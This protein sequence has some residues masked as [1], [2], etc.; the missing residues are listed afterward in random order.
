MAPS[1]SNP[2]D[3]GAASQEQAVA[4]VLQAMRRA[5]PEWAPELQPCGEGLGSQVWRAE[6]PAWGPVAIRVPRQRIVSNANEQ[7][8]ESRALL[9]QERRLS[10]YLAPFGLPVP[11]VFHLHDRDP[12]PYF[13]VTAYVDND[14]TPADPVAVGRLLAR[15][16]AV[17]A[18]PDWTPVAQVGETLARTLATR[19][20][21][22]SR[23]IELLTGESLTGESLT[24][25]ALDVP[26]PEELE[27]LLLRTTGARSLLHLD[28]REPNILT[29]R[30]AIAGL[31]DWDNCLIGDPALEIAR[32]SESGLW[33][34]SM[35]SG[36]G[37]PDP[38]AAIPEP[39][40]LLYRLYTATMLALVFLSEAPDPARATPAVERVRHLWAQYRRHAS[41]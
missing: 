2:T 32:V 26:G 37:A 24:G 10:A 39:V 35:A 40:A 31:I 7:G 41:Q 5:L 18:P 30:T 23:T 1:S 38:L 3:A 8:I 4:S 15:L 28:Y 11:R 29:S 19:I 13:I 6:H 16:H 25:L 21:Q 33:L 12:G 14:R 34:P 22:R 20:H 9:Q 17:P 27:R 36:Y